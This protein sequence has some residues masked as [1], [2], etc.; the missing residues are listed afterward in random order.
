VAG[1]DVGDFFGGVLCFFVAH[2]DGTVFGTDHE[3][4]GLNQE[5]N[6]GSSDKKERE[7]QR[8]KNQVV[9]TPFPKILKSLKQTK[10]AGGKV[11]DMS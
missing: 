10:G 2:E 5:C 4:C 9:K 6:D 7:R 8:K 3:F 11:R 1:V